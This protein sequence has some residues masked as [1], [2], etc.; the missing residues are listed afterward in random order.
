MWRYSLTDA[1]LTKSRHRVS[2]MR[3]ALNIMAVQ[4]FDVVGVTELS[5]NQQG[6]L[7]LPPNHGTFSPQ[8]RGENG[9]TEEGQSK[10]KKGKK[11]RTQGL[12]FALKAGCFLCL[13]WAIFNAVRP[14]AW[15]KTRYYAPFV[16]D[17]GLG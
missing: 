9:D 7:D 14:V 3:I 16:Q 4:E 11:E 15:C 5:P 13:S 1:S 10:K 6:V 17:S 8:L 12:K 2:Q